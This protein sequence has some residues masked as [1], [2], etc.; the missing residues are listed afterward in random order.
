MGDSSAQNSAMISSLCAELDLLEAKIGQHCSTETAAKTVRQILGCYSNHSVVDPDIYV[1]QLVELLTGYPSCIV[2]ALSDPKTGIVAFARF[3]PTPAQIK[4]H[5]D[6]QVRLLYD[7]RNRLAY[8]TQEHT[9]HFDQPKERYSAEE[10][11]KKV[12][13]FKRT[14]SRTQP[15][16]D[17]R[18][19]D[20]C[21]RMIERSQSKPGAAIAAFEKSKTKSAD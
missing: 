18:T 10:I 3:L 1:G 4:D 8:R 9:D 13:A 12:D 14:L 21:R 11:R 7:R 17:V 15:N 20:H 16:N 2:E 5:L 19:S 6:H